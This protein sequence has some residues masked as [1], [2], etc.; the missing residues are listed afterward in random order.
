VAL[1]NV[2]QVSDRL[3]ELAAL[4]I[5]IGWHK[6]IPPITLDSSSLPDTGQVNGG[7]RIRQAPDKPVQLFWY[8]AGLAI[9][10][11]SISAGAP[12]WFDMLLKLVNVRRSGKKPE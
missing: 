3:G 5:P 7:H 1:D 6:G 12:F 2:Q 4:G 9:T 8:V 10:A 11:F